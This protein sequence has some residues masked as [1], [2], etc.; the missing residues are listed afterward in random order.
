MCNMFQ[1]SN[2]KKILHVKVLFPKHDPCVNLKFDKVQPHFG[3]TLEV[4]RVPK[5]NVLSK[6]FKKFKILHCMTQT[7]RN[8]DLNLTRVN[9]S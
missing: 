2:S 8:C 6:A 3:P 1:S 5:L 7:R 4:C 9:Q